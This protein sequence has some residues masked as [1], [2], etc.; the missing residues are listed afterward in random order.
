MYLKDR[1]SVMLNHNPF[2]A[3][4]PDPN[5]DNNHQVVISCKLIKLKNPWEFVCNIDITIVQFI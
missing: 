5:T 1:R 2:M 4:Q 3:F